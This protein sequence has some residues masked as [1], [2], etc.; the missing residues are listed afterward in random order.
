MTRK[1][2]PYIT[3]A[4]CVVTVGQAW[5]QA[6]RAVTLDIEWENSVGYLD[7]LPDPSKLVTSPGIAT[8]NLRNFMRFIAIADII[9]VNGK[10]AKGT[11]V[12]GGRLV[13]VFRSPMPGQ[14]IGDLAVRGSMADIHLEILDNDGTPVGTIMTSG[15]TGG[16]APPGLPGFCNLAVIGGT[17]AFQGVT[18]TVAS[19]NFA[20]RPTSMAEDPASR[21]INGGPRGHFFAYLISTASPEIVTTAS[22]PAVFHSDFSPVTSSRPARSG[23]TLIVTATGLGPTRPGLIPG[24]P[25]PDSPLQEVNSPLEVTVNGKPADVLNKFGWPGTTDTYRVDIRVPDGT[26]PGMAALQ[27][28]AAFVQG[29]RVSIPIQ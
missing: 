26:A 24:T 15:F 20:T 29:R 2:K 12:L 6:P 9:S 13:Q 22:G 19:P 21:R 8:L 16:N 10:P 23:E 27:V 14:A 5:A 28:T 11:W 25:F 1:W 3:A 18:G 4:V 7:D 17:G